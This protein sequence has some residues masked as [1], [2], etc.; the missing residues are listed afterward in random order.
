M[1]VLNGFGCI[2]ITFPN[3]IFASF[4]N[5]QVVTVFSQCYTC[6]TG[7]FSC[8]FGSSDSTLVTFWTGFQ[9]IRNMTHQSNVLISIFFYVY[10]CEWDEFAEDSQVQD[11]FFWLKPP[12]FYSGKILTISIQQSYQLSIRPFDSSMKGVTG[13]ESRVYF[14]TPET[15]GVSSCLW[16]KIAHPHPKNAY[17]KVSLTL[18]HASEQIQRA[19]GMAKTHQMLQAYDSSM[20]VY[21]VQLFLN[22]FVIEKALASGPLLITLRSNSHNLKSTF[23]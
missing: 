16:S 23:K 15:Q 2:H 5:P 1:H 22:V 9:A 18:A 17:G 10:L 6:F 12:V 20:R 4:V 13:A 14:L 21:M 7:T 11:V 8:Q 3:I 19:R